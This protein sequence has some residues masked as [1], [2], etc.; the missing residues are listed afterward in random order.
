MALSNAE[1]QARWRAKRNK[2][3]KQASTVGGLITALAHHVKGKS[4]QEIEAIIARVTAR[5]RQ[6]TRRAEPT[7]K[8][9]QP[10]KP[11]LV[12]EES[13]GGQLTAK[14]ERGVK[15]VVTA[16]SGYG[17]GYAARRETRAGNYVNLG[18][19]DTSEQAKELCERYYAGRGD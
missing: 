11:A 16:A 5:L 14:V 4:D 13:V 2:L 17:L 7:H 18:H 19:A 3:A 8:P 1:V 6:S 15:Y 12:W 9:K 10:T